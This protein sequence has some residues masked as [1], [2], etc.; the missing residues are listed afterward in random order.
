M[1]T[2]ANGAA[3]AKLSPD[4]EAASAVL[5]ELCIRPFAC[6]AAPSA[7][8]YAELADPVHTKRHWNKH[9]LRRT[10]K[11]SQTILAEVPVSHQLPLNWYDTPP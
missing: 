11:K 6:I 5:L 10:Q 9:K 2:A 8:G 3:N 7:L 1:S 4:A